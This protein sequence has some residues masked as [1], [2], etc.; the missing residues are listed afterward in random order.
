MILLVTPRYYPD[1]GGVEYVVKST[2]ERFAALGHETT[3][4]TGDPK[5]DK[6]LEE[7]ING[8]QVIRWPTWAPGGAYHIPKKRD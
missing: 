5:A 1:V 2:A 7:E 3:V 4:V 8:V 6:P